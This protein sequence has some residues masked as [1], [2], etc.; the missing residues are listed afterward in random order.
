[1]DLLSVPGKLR[2]TSTHADINQSPGPTG[3][4]LSILEAPGVYVPGIGTKDVMVKALFEDVNVINGSDQLTLYAGVNENK[5]VRAGIHQGNVYIMSPN[6]GAGDMNTFTD[7][8][9]FSTGDD[10]E[11]TLSRQSGVWSLSWNNLTSGNTGSL[12]G[13]SL[14][15]LD[16]EPNLYFG[17]LAANAGNVPPGTSGV[18][19]FVSQIDNFTVT[20]IP[21]P[22][23]LLVAGMSLA[24][25]LA[26]Q[27]KRRRG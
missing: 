19:S 25:L 18:Q 13:V 3:N 26:S 9:A 24:G 15:W 23:G 1:M 14:P 20:C 22:S 4:N 11:V 12:A 8:N 10:I 27:G 5:V 16:E 21:E 6:N 17:I 7:A 2:V